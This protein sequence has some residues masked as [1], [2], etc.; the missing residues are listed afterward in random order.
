[1]AAH[2][3]DARWHGVLTVADGLALEALCET[4][5]D[6]VEAREALKERGATTY[7]SANGLIRPYPQVA[8]AADADR[9][10]KTWL[11]EFGM[12][13]AARAKVS[14]AADEGDENRFASL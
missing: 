2:R 1:V 13:P 6:L 7:Q 12:T 4:Y 11:N 9:R 3:A 10:L 8:H 14:A 5:A